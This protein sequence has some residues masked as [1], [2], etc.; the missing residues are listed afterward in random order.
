[1]E[2]MLA[3]NAHRYMI[4]P[5]YTGILQTCNVGINKP[6]KDRLKKKVSNWRSE[7]FSSLRP[8]EL[9]PSPSRKQFIS[10]LQDIWEFFRYKL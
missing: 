4:P 5:H 7:K 10:W 8:G 6:L 1:M 9:L 2:A 3:D